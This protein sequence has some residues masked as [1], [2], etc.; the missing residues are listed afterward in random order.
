MSRQKR[1]AAAASWADGATTVAAAAPTSCPVMRSPS[2]V[3]GAVISTTKGWS[4]ERPSA[5]NNS[6]PPTRSIV[7]SAVASM[8]NVPL[9]KRRPTS[10]SLRQPTI[11]PAPSR[12]HGAGTA[13]APSSPFNA[14]WFD[15][16][17]RHGAPRSTSRRQPQ[18]VALHRGPAAHL[19]QQL[20]ATIEPARAAGRHLER[21]RLGEQVP[22]GIALDEQA[23]AVRT[24]QPEVRV[25]GREEAVDADVALRHHR[26]EDATHPHRRRQ[27]G[28]VGHEPIAGAQDLPM[29]PQAGALLGRHDDVCAVGTEERKQLAVGRFDR[30]VI[31][32]EAR[33][34][35]GRVEG[36]RT[37]QRR[38]AEQRR[39]TRH[40]APRAARADAPRAAAGAVASGSASARST[41]PR[42]PRCW[43]PD[44]RARTRQRSRAWRAR[45]P[46]A[47]AVFPAARPSNAR[48]DAARRSGARLAARRAR[49]PLVSTGHGAGSRRCK[50]SARA[51][52]IRRPATD[53]GRRRR[54]FAAPPARRHAT[55]AAAACGRRTG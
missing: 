18:L 48:A 38:I 1:A 16:S 31:G 30:V 17:K 8:R 46:P 44:D 54:G 52:T 26:M 7:V 29:R 12:R 51:A 45:L 37:Q 11:T 25:G 32:A 6:S 9:G 40:G 4:R 36:R 15:T 22:G 55:R 33:G 19:E 3:P 50:S 13:S 24:E 21:G 39:R 49:R 23:Q 35:F 41:K 20:L 27:R 14:T 34:Q 28:L 42:S 43:R 53:G 2:D 47:A 5:N 10:D